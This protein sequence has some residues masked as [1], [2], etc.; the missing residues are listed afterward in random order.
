M[1]GKNR[2]VASAHRQ[3]VGSGHSWPPLLADKKPEPLPF[4]KDGKLW[5]DGAAVFLTCEGP[6]ES[7][8]LELWVTGVVDGVKPDER[9]PKFTALMEKYLEFAKQQTRCGM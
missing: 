5:D 2:F 1:D 6:A 9:R 8:E 3:P 4:V 7:F